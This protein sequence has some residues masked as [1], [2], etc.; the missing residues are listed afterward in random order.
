M[1]PDRL[2]RGFCFYIGVIVSFSENI[3]VDGSDH[4]H[5]GTTIPTAYF[6]D[7]D[8][9]GIPDTETTPPKDQQGL[10]TSGITAFLM[11]KARITS[12]NELKASWQ[13]TA[14]TKTVN[15]FTNLTS[16][17]DWGTWQSA[18]SGH[19]IEN[20][21]EP[22]NYRMPSGSG[23]PPEDDNQPE[24]VDSDTDW[25]NYENNTLFSVKTIEQQKT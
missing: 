7:T 2:F 1:V 12:T 9:D 20:L 3:I 18:A 16:G 24:W 4:Y 11:K 14:R 15:T 6:E 13:D 21:E 23:T 19:D 17:D 8:S 22:L 5:M 25:S 10:V